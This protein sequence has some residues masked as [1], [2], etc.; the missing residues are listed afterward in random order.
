LAVYTV[1][2]WHCISYGLNPQAESAKIDCFW[3]RFALHINQLFNKECCM[4]HP[5]MPQDINE[6]RI[7]KEWHEGELYYSVID[8]I[9]ELLDADFKRAQNYYHQLKNKLKKNSI[10]IPDL[11]Q[12]KAVSKDKKLYLTDFATM[13]GIEML[14][15]HLQHNMQKRHLRV[16]VRQDDEVICFHQ[17]VIN[18]L[19]II[20]L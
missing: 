7:R 6:G 11:I 5:M 1:T 4:E 17:A 10:H 2:L 8:I 12:I 19:S 14:T 16:I 9:A 13:Q 3:P 15:A 18:E 20:F